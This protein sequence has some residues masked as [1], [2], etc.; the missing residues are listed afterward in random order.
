[1]NITLCG[2]I[3]FFD[4]MTSLQQQLGQLGHQVK[5]PR[6]TIPDKDG[7][8]VP[9]PKFYELKKAAP[10]TDAWMWARINENI[11]MHFDKIAWSEAVLICNWDKNGIT[12]YIGGNTLIEMGVALYLKKKIFLL[13]PIP[14]M[15]YKEE[16]LAMQPIILHHNFKLLQ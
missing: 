13:N 15:S 8:P 6:D 3:A 12:H 9:S 11:V 1:M 5:I 4:D 10:D 16:I 14:E 2:S 7:R